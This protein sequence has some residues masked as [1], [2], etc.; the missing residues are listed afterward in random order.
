LE[1]TIETTIPLVP[2]SPLSSLPFP[3]LS[4]K[5]IP[6]TLPVSGAGAC[7]RT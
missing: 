4:K 3:F 5:T 7:G 6:H 2:V 1:S